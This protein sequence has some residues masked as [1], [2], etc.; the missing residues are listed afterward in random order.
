[1]ITLIHFTPKFQGTLIKYHGTFKV[2]QPTYENEMDVWKYN[3]DSLIAPLK[4]G[5]SCSVCKKLDVVDANNR[6]LRL[7]KNLEFAWILVA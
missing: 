3:E 4:Q 1:M 5:R 6:G 2:L 7:W